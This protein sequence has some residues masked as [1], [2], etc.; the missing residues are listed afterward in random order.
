MSG[1]E[2][3]FNRRRVEADGS[4]TMTWRNHSRK[5]VGPVDPKVTVVRICDDADNTIAILCHYACH[6]VTLGGRNR[7]LTA[8]WPGYT[9]AYL[10]RRFPGATALFLQGG[11]GDLDPRIDV[12]RD[13][14]PAKQQGEDVGRSA[15][16]AAKQGDRPG[17]ARRPS[18]HQ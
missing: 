1:S 10:E 3:S 2:I 9:C 14:L 7:L 16:D 18:R 6:P 13:F 15:E 17:A 8:D 11:C 12:Q 5:H 4:V